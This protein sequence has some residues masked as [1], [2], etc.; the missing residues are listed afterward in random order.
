MRRTP[1]PRRRPPRRPAR[2]RRRPPPHRR[3]T[4]D[5]LTIGTVTVPVEEVAY[6]AGQPRSGRGQAGQAA[7]HFPDRLALHGYGHPVGSVVT[8]SV[9]LDETSHH[10]PLGAGQDADR[11]APPDLDEP[12]GDR[13]A[14]D[15]HRHQLGHGGHLH[16]PV[17]GHQVALRAGL[18]SRP[19]TVRWA[20]TRAPGAG[21]GRTP[22]VAR[23]GGDGSDGAGEGRGTASVPE[24][25][26]TGVAGRGGRGG[27]G[28]AGDG[29]HPVDG[30]G[31]ERARASC[32]SAADR[33]RSA[34]PEAP[35]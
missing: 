8:D 28:V 22:P 7:G 20:T 32:A 29:G 5:W 23:P 30:D 9:R 11:E 12:P 31:Q 21:A 14:L 1:V 13:V 34:P 15:G 24:R 6:L 35:L 33:R 3:P 17:A 2:P 10:G 19:R 26:A 4:R 25:V 27:R 16:H 18:G